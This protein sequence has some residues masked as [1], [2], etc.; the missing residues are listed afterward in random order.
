MADDPSASRGSHVAVDLGEKRI[1]EF[2][3]RVHGMRWLTTQKIRAWISPRATFPVRGAGGG[4]VF[5]G[6]FPGSR[7]WFIQAADD[8]WHF[9]P[10][11]FNFIRG[12]GE[13]CG[14]W[15]FPR[16]VDHACF[17][18]GAFVTDREVFKPHRDGARRLACQIN[19]KRKMG[20]VFPRPFGRTLAGP[21][22]DRRAA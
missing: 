19:L 7:H 6:L 8:A 5:A 1:R 10:G 22:S 21:G 15:F 12:L 18:M 17:G 3:R 4:N 20:T 13:D 9:A 2:D 16:G 14:R 11:G